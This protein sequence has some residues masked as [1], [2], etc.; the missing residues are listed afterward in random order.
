MFLQIIALGLSILLRGAFCMEE[1]EYDFRPGQFVTIGNST[2]IWYD[3]ELRMPRAAV[4][5]LDCSKFA[6]KTRL[7][8]FFIFSLHFA[9]QCLFSNIFE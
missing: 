5:R 1:E 2:K 3:Y 6:G 8:I 7:Y 9:I 4:E